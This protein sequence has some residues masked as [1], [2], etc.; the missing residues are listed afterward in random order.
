MLG[1]ACSDLVMGLFMG[2]TGST[3]LLEVYDERGI[4]YLAATNAGWLPYLANEGLQYVHYST[5]RVRRQFRL[6]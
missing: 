4:T 3:T 5:H 1:T 6:D 2:T